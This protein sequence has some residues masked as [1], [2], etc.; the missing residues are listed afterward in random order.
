VADPPHGSEVLPGSRITYTISYSNPSSFVAEAAVLSDTYDLRDSYAVLATIPPAADAAHS[1]WQLGDVPPEAS[2]DIQVMVKLADILPNHWP[3][4]NEVELSFGGTAPPVTDVV[5][6]MVLYGGVALVDL[7]VDDIRWQPAVPAP[8]DQVKFYATI[9]NQGTA[10]A[11]QYFWVSLYIKPQ[12]SSPPLGPS[13]HLGG[14]CLDAACTT[15]RPHFLAYVPSL[16]PGAS[17]ELSFADLEADPA[18]PASGAYD[19]YVQVDMAFTDP[20]N[21]DY[22]NPY[23]GHYPED[24]EQNNLW[25]KALIIPQA[26]PPRIYLPV[27]RSTGG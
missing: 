4:S 24:Y 14:Y 3:V 6:H 12:P 16:A 19:I 2:G 23:W 13:D 18:F 5:T 25:Y 22:Y 10:A 15:P 1:I 9:T 20:A 11:S 27:V 8:G 21:P 17:V 7:R 26:G